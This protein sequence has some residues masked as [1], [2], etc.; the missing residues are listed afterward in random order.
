MPIRATGKKQPVPFGGL[1]QGLSGC[2]TQ[3]WP[4]TFKALKSCFG[5][6]LDVGF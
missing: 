6:G 4:Q 1:L 5:K 3:M 2:R